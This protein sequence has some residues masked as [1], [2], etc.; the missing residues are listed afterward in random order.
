VFLQLLHTHLLPT[1]A[2]CDSTIQA[3]RYHISDLALGLLKSQEGVSYVV[4]ITPN[5]TY[6]TNIHTHTIS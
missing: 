6:H 3:Q 5:N 4:R 2:V 1:P